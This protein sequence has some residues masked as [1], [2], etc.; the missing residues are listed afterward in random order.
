MIFM[1]AKG[2]G[3]AMLPLAFVASLFVVWGWFGA[4][5]ELFWAFFLRPWLVTVLGTVS[6]MISLGFATALV[7]STIALVV[8]AFIS[9]M[10]TWTL[11]NF[12]LWL[13]CPAEDLDASRDIHSFLDLS[14][15]Q[16]FYDVARRRQRQS[17]TAPVASLDEAEL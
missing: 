7:Q 1:L 4:V 12:G 11:L 3:G 13:R 5:A 8:A 6:T 10:L 15:R 16:A 9:P 14:W 2:I 17:Y